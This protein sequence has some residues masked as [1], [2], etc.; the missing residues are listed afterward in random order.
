LQ[1]AFPL[2]YG[3]KKAIQK[4]M[5]WGVNLGLRPISKINYKIQRFNRITNIDSAATLFEGS[6]GLNEAFAGTG[7]QIK[8]FSI[9]ANVG[10]IFGNKTY[11]TRLLL[12]NDTVNYLRSNSG[13]K[14]SIGGLSFN[15]GMQYMIPIKTGDTVKSV[16]KIGAY[17]TLQKS[18]TATQDIVRETF[19]F[20]PVSGSTDKLDSVF[21][22]NGVKG[23]VQLPATYGIG[24][25][26]ETE[27]WIYGV[28]LETS[29]WNNYR[30]F[31]QKDLVQN[32]WTVK[33][34]FQ[35]LPA[36]INSRKYS[37]Y[38]KYR[39]GIFFGPD[40]I[41]ADKKLPQY[42]VS[43]GAGFPLK[44]RQSFYETQRS[45]M[46]LALE[47]GSRGNNSNNIRENILRIS[48]GFTL[49]DVWFRRYKYD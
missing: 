49:S 17:G 13:T 34:G 32:N 37:Q 33:A 1:V 30:F 27:H 19:V 35:Y 39:A 7:I 2:L 46:N 26:M 43:V 14:T 38:V 22:Q 31:G 16:F 42:A 45:V 5:G 3:N 15:A 12:L 20:N 4:K 25:L 8:N 44:L 41:V 18:F 36:R 40:Y 47:Y 28:D 9:G 11:N 29:N 21:Q 24:F 23:K 6:G 10:Y 48:L